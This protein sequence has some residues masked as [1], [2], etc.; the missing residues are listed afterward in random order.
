[1]FRGL[2]T[3]MA[4]LKMK[5]AEEKYDPSLAT[6]MFLTPPGDN[7]VGSNKSSSAGRV[8]KSE[9]G[10]SGKKILQEKMARLKRAQELLKKSQSPEKA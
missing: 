5:D 4:S 3:A 1:M 9:D 6:K 7:D 10:G 8:D 2:K